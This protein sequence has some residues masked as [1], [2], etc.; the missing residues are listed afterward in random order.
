[1]IYP[2]GDGTGEDFIKRFYI[3]DGF[4]TN[5]G[6]YYHEAVD[7]NGRG[8]GNTDLGEPLKAISDGKLVYYHKGSHPTKGF[9]IHSVY[10]ID[11]AFGK[12]WVHYAHCMEKDFLSGVQDVR[13]GQ[14]IARMGNSGTQYVHLHM[15]IFKVDPGTLPNG[16]DTIAKTKTQLNQ[17]F[18][19]PI[20]FI[21]KAMEGNMGDEYG[22][23]VW[24][25]TQH[26]ETVKYIWGDDKDPRQT[27]SKDIQQ[28]IAGLKSQSTT[29]RND[30]AKCEAEV[31]NRIEQ[32][33]RLEV[34]LLEEKAFNKKLEAAL[35]SAND[36]LQKIRVDYEGRIALLQEQVD[37][38]ASQKGELNKKIAVLEADLAECKKN[39][40]PSCW[41]TFI[42]NIKKLFER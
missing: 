22:D 34:Q 21:K 26:D 13:E 18:E 24:K 2:V 4:G 12:R 19:A 23:M 17:W 14:M 16:I 11:T 25:S 7:I 30:L 36:E 1:M 38:L 3:A 5:R 29:L 28:Y 20:E 37:G 39:N 40:C 33:S 31:K 9:G 35:F 32:V 27:P 6:T 15:S 41:E 8:G 10:S 42:T